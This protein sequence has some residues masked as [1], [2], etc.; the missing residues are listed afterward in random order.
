MIT[1]LTVKDVE[2]TDTGVR[3]R[4]GRAS[5]QLPE[6]VAALARAV[7]ANRKGHATIGALAPSPGSFPAASP[8]GRSA[9]HRCQ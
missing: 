2:A 7:A 8:V 3:L 9:P 1:R 4:L 6:P 5:I